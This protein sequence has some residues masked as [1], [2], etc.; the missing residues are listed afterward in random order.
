MS[1]LTLELGGKSHVWEGDSNVL[2]TTARRIVW[3]KFLNAAQT[4]MVP[5]PVLAQCRYRLR[6]CW[7][8]P[9]G[10]VPD[11]PL[12]AEEILGPVL[13]LVP[14]E[15]A[16]HAVEFVTARDKPLALYVFTEEKAVKELFRRRTSA[17]ARP[18]AGCPSTRRCCS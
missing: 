8:R 5:N 15:S 12:M 7:G 6:V 16:Q 11:G 18:S 3:G 2:R 9:G 17:G 10:M 14:V 4:H 13:P 1:P